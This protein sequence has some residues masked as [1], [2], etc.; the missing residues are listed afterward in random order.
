MSSAP[1]LGKLL[2]AVIHQY[3]DVN[4]E[5][6]NHRIGET[7]NPAQERVQGNLKDNDKS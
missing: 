6:R 1:L 4:Q 3:R 2:K 7:E 5:T